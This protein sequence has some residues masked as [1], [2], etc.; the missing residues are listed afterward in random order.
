MVHLDAILLKNRQ[1][2]LLKKNNY[3]EGKNF[4]MYLR[5]RRTLFEQGIKNE[6]LWIKV[7]NSKAQNKFVA[8]H[9]LRSAQT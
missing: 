1:E 5:L 6:K 7:A 9:A 8:L 4:V 2:D 3:K